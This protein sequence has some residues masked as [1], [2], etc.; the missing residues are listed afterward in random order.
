MGN[1]PQFAGTWHG[2]TPWSSLPLKSLYF[3]V[4]LDTF[5]PMTDLRVS[6]SPLPELHQGG[7][8]VYLDSHRSTHGER[9]AYPTE[10]LRGHLWNTGANWAEI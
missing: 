8:S 9:Y 5:P 6:P 1:G 2:M 7:H 3:S 10:P 4:W